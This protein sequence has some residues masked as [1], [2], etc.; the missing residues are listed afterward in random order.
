MSI[1]RRPSLIIVLTSLLFGAIATPPLAWLAASLH[2]RLQ[3]RGRNPNSLTTIR[4]RAA[5]EGEGWLM[6]S[7]TSNWGSSYWSIS[8]RGAGVT[9]PQLG[10]AGVPE[11]RLPS[12][13]IDLGAP[14]LRDASL[15]PGDG[16]SELRRLHAAGWPLRCF[17]AIQPPYSGAWAPF[18]GYW[19]VKIPYL[20]PGDAAVTPLPARPIWSRLILN[21]LLLGFAF[22]AF[23]QTIIFL[24]RKLKARGNRCPHCGYDLA[25]LHAGAPCPECGHVRDSSTN[26]APPPSTTTI[27]T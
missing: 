10:T 16:A 2:F 18:Q 12:W 4:Q 23:L 7:E 1:P 15:W 20:T 26:E 5:Q 13:A 27:S 25:G 14:F 24:R 21:A 11:N 19:S 6:V 17:Y 22:G 8:A 9:P 3:M